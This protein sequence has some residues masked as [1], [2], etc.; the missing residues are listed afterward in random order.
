M[1]EFF[2]G[3]G[4][5][6]R[7]LFIILVFGAFPVLTVGYGL[8][9][10]GLLEDERSTA[11]LLAR[12]ERGLTAVYNVDDERVLRTRLVKYVFRRIQKLVH[13][14]SAI[15]PV[16]AKRLLER[17]FRFFPDQLELYFFDKNGY[18]PALSRGPRLKGAL[19]RGFRALVNGQFSRRLTGAEHGLLCALFRVNSASMLPQ[20]EGSYQSLIPRPHDS[21]MLWNVNVSR[22]SPILGYIAVFHD[23]PTDFDRPL[24]RAIKRVNSIQNEITLGW[25]R[26]DPSGAMY[27]TPSSIAGDPDI[28]KE[29]LAAFSRFDRV[30]RTE[31]SLATVVSR[32]RGG[33]LI[34][35]SKRPTLLAPRSRLFL[36]LIGVAWMLLIFWKCDQ[37]GAGFGTRLPLKLGGLFLLAAG[38]PSVLL[39]VSGSYALRD[40]A[41]VRRQMLEDFVISRMR[42]FDERLGERFSL[43]EHSLARVVEKAQQLKTSEARAAVF[44]GLEK[45]EM[46]DQLI[47]INSKGERLV[48][49]FKPGIQIPDAQKKLLYNM[50]Q[51]VV[52]RLQ[53]SSEV[54]AATLSVDTV[55]DLAGGIMGKDFLSVDQIIGGMKRFQVIQ[56]GSGNGMFYENTLLGDNGQPE[57]LVHVGLDRNNFQHDYCKR[58]YRSLRRANDLPIRLG[59][60]SLEKS[61]W[62]VIDEAMDGRTARRMAALANVGRVIARDIVRENGED[63]LWIGFPC[64]ILDGYTL[65]ARASLGSVSTAIDQLWRQLW[66]LAG[67]LLCSGALMAWLLTEQV[68]LPLR[69][70]ATG[71]EAIARRDFRHRVPVR[72]ADELGEIAGLMNRVT[73]GMRDL[74]VARVVQES[75][76][77]LEGITSG[78]FEIAG[79]SRAMTDIGGDYFDYKVID[80][81]YLVGLIG[82]VAGHGVPAALIMGMAK[83]AFSLLARSDQPLDA[84]VTAFN[85]L[86]VSQG[87]KRK[88]MMTMFCFALD[89]KT[90]HL[91]VLNSGHNFP[92]LFK[93]ETGA[94]KEIEIVGHPLGVRKKIVLK[95]GQIDLA[96]GDALVLYTDGLIESR[97]ASG[98]VI[99]YQR[100]AGWVAEQA[101]KSGNDAKQFAGA[102]FAA[103]DEFIGAEPAGDDVTVVCLRRRPLVTGAGN[104]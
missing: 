30:I 97:N 62:D 65:V 37:I 91:D 58:E 49:Y 92:F 34:A 74:E 59:A 6:F 40:H 19:E 67:M 25:C 85:E 88:H 1:T 36:E 101:S 93:A 22:K 15:P 72:S 87:V 76:L 50:G 56:F 75:L 82:D 18:V 45:V 78:E 11:S 57:W 7:G 54:D 27:F 16:E 70:V 31:Q 64:R 26:Q 17:L 23:G 83:S 104:V 71:I 47:V 28:M 94:A 100:A 5:F 51:E 84:F 80:D 77:P 4:R 52:R 33:Y 21:G 90:G 55:T 43:L 61:P 29:T 32:Q 48:S 89:L 95:R 73:E 79:K 96:P 14:P 41:N 103:F 3:A 68:L 42:T 98:A 66:L 63:M 102:I 9:Q 38:I 44:R 81:R 53:G 20:L 2:P 39:I 13:D 46:V 8:R 35:V 60:V 99:G 12:Q 69:D 24:R 86:L 10:I